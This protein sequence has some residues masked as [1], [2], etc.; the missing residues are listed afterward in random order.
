M[1]IWFPES[2]QRTIPK[3]MK[4]FAGSFSSLVGILI[5]FAHPL[6]LMGVSQLSLGI[7]F[8]LFAGE[9]RQPGE[10]RLEYFKKPRVIVSSLLLLIAMISSLYFLLQNV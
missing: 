2:R 1:E 3:W 5:L 6:D 7:W 4:I 9:L 8:L 10:S